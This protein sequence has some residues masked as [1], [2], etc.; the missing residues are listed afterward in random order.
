MPIK[1][2]S[3]KQIKA[4][5]HIAWKFQESPG[6]P[7]KSARRKAKSLRPASRQGRPARAGKPD[8]FGTLVTAAGEALG[9]SIEPSWQAGVTF[10]LQLLFKHAALVD[11]FPLPDE[12][13]PAPVFRA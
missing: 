11:Q 8:A 4:Y 3:L 13:E 7:R 10:N 5:L 9:L 12:A 1:I 2:K 6:M